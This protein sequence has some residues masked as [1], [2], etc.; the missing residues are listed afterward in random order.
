MNSF[1]RFMEEKFIP[2]AAKIGAQR[3][4]V[5]IRDAFVSIMALLIAGSMGVLINNMQFTRLVENDPYQNF[6]NNL[7]GGLGWKDF[8]GNLW[9][10]SFAI[11][12]IFIAFLVAYN[13]AKSYDSNGI[14]A[15]VTSTAVFFMFIPKSAESIWGFTNQMGLFVAIIVGLVVAELFVRL[16]R[17]K[18]LVIKMPESVPPSV[19][20]AFAALLPTLI[21]MSIAAFFHIFM[22]AIE[23]D[24]FS[25]IMTTI[26]APIQNVG[27][28]LFVAL[29]LPLIQQ[30]F[31]FFGIH[32]SNVIDP[33]MQAI[34]VPAVVENA[35]A[36]LAGLDAPNIVT[37]SFYDAFVNMGGS[38]TTIA[39]IAA[40]FV[41][42]KRKDYRLVG[43]MSAA[44]GLFNINESIL[45]GLPLVLNPIMLIPFV[46]TPMLLT[47]IAYV[48]TAIG[49]V[50]ATINVI[51]W[52]TPPVLGGFFA[53]G[54]IR[55]A[56]LSLFNLVVAFVIYYIFVLIA[57]KSK[58]AAEHV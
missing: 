55:G 11:M 34:Y 14:G 26:Q 7:F 23:K 25:V 4:L 51:P 27:D 21:I 5:A 29:L 43:G 24:L 57:N 52:V 12:S 13:L 30:F 28:T 45:F 35:N 39:L 3:H 19:G 10:A 56:L 50:P 32:G 31:W 41:G 42:S 46:F 37:K 53:T 17:S 1:M 33:V 20:R 54:D 18:A 2:V 47:L 8:G 9:W 49:L 22:T 58:D 6:M 48:A 44:P 15:G 36:I 40:I 16:S 38:G